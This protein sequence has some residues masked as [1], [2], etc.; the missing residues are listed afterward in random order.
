MKIH[1]EYI[2]QLTEEFLNSS[3]TNLLFCEGIKDGFYQTI[4]QI[5]KEFESQCFELPCS[6]NASVGM[7]LGAA[8]YGLSPI[9]CFQR[10]EFALLA[11]EQ[12]VNNSSK[13]SFLTDNKR[14]NPSLFRF[15]IGRGWG[16]GPS[17]SQSLET[18]FAQIPD[19]NVVIPV[20]PEDSKLI[21]ETF[22]NKST[23]T[24][25]LEHR[26]IHFNK[27]SNVKPKELAPY[28]IKKGN[29]LT[30]VA[31]AYDVVQSLIVAKILEKYQISVEVINFFCLTPFSYENIYRSIK[32]TK[33]IIT[34]DINQSFY[35]GSSEL[36]A[37][38]YCLGLDLNNSPV[39]LG[40]KSSFS[41]SSRHLIENYYI[42]ISDITLAI[43]NTLKIQPNLKEKIMNEV[44]VLKNQ[45]PNDIPNS[46]FAGP[47]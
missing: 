29:D 22:S 23:P 32:K 45:R 39:R 37:Q 16:Q 1:F 25:C 33:N 12:L 26:W 10:V 30:I 20:F 28:V 19:L 5:T 15:V 13:I 38:L 9:I 40:A 11:V 2:K 6:E 44:E 36:I 3:K 42:D 43:L 17:H 4:P 21:F 41:P 18:I 14:K 8:C 34:I 31:C 24:I 27:E 46:D 7:I 47:F 35:G